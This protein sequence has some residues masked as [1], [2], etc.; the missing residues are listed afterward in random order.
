[1][2]V[3]H[4]LRA[5]KLQRV[6]NKFNNRKSPRKHRTLHSDPMSSDRFEY[7]NNIFGSKEDGDGKCDFNIAMDGN[8]DV[9][10]SEMSKIFT[11]DA[12]KDTIKQAS[13]DDKFSMKMEITGLT[14]CVEMFKCMDPK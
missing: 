12:F 3:D 9:N 4:L 13:S 6:T 1:M 5:A 2:P 7:C 14:S 8:L 11:G 10:L